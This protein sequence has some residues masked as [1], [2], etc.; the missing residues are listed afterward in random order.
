MAFIHPELIEINHC[1]GLINVIFVEYNKQYPM[2][3]LFNSKFI[4]SLGFPFTAFKL[5]SVRT[6]LYNI[7]SS[8]THLDLKGVSWFCIR[9]RF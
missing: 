7:A 3:V 9:P 8:M 4:Y 5:A 1:G 6:I 2:K